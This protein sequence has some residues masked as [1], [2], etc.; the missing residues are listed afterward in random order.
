MLACNRVGEKWLMTEGRNIQT[1]SNLCGNLGLKEI[2]KL[3]ADCVK[4]GQFWIA[5]S[6]GLYFHS[7]PA[8]LLFLYVYGARRSMNRQHAL[9]VEQE[10]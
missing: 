2:A 7:R 10:P 9:H 4:V 3:I 8:A 6:S 1:F 5:I